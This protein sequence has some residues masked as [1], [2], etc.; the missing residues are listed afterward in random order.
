ML[1]WTSDLPMTTGYGGM[2]TLPEGRPFRGLE[3]QP[4]C[5][6]GEESWQSQTVPSPRQKSNWAGSGYSRLT[7]RTTPSRGCPNIHPCAWAAG[8][9]KYDRPRIYRHWLQKASAG[10]QQRRKP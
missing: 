3:V 10:V 4:R 2:V 5:N 9:G 7:T 8:R 6:S 1:S